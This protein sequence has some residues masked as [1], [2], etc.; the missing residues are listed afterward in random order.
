MG[1][2]RDASLSMFAN[3]LREYLG[4]APLD[5]HAEAPRLRRDQREAR[6]AIGIPLHAEK[7]FDG[8]TPIR[9]SG[10]L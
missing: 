2:P 5:Y 8:R 7:W 3:A 4:L 6:E 10:R 1:A 9:G